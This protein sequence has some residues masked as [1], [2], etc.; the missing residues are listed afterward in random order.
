MDNK[1]N[2]EVLMS[3]KPFKDVGSDVG[4]TSREQEEPLLLEPNRLTQI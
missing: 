4:R 2:V 3:S 1:A